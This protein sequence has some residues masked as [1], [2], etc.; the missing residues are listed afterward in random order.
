MRSL[1]AAGSISMQSLENPMVFDGPHFSLAVRLTCVQTPYLVAILITFYR[2][3]RSI[4]PLRGIRSKRR[5]QGSGTRAQASASVS[6][7]LDFRSLRLTPCTLCPMPHA[8]CL[9]CRQP[10][11]RRSLPAPPALRLAPCARETVGTASLIL[12]PRAW[13]QPASVESNLWWPLDLPQTELSVAIQVSSE[14]GLCPD[15]VSPGRQVVAVCTRCR[16]ATR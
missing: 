14:R 10:Q 8:L 9:S 5:D 3:A 1:S 13:S 7:L 16:L 15:V 2:F 6:C 12:S 4:I 11:A